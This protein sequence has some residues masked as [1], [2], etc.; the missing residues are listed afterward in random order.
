MKTKLCDTCSMWSCVYIEKFTNTTI[1]V[2]TVQKVGGRICEA[3][4]AESGG[5]VWG[6]AVS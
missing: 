4:R 3:R 6:S 2:T 1:G 5:G